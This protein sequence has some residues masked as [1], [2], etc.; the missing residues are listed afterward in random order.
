MIWKFVRGSPATVRKVCFAENP[1]EGEVVFN[2]GAYLVGLRP[3]TKAF[4]SICPHLG[5]RL[6]YDGERQSFHCPCH[7]SRFSQNGRWIEGP[8]G[9]NMTVLDLSLDEKCG[10]YV[11]RL[12]L[13]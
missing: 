9:K 2:E 7:G 1:S 8:A 13:V 5:C 6:A 11:A 4:S 3:K 10:D 12:P